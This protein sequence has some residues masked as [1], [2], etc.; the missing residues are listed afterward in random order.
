MKEAQKTITSRPF[1]VP[2]GLKF[3]KIDRNTG[4]TPGPTT[5]KKDIIFEVFKSENYHKI[6]ESNTESNIDTEQNYDTM[7]Y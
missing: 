7:I 5:L 6:Y 1:K 4:K 3:A 2:P